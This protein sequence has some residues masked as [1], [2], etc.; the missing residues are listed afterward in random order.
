MKRIKVPAKTVQN[1]SDVFDNLQ[2][3]VA[4]NLLRRQDR[5]YKNY[6]LIFDEKNGSANSLNWKVELV[7]PHTHTKF[8]VKVGESQGTALGL[9][10]SGEII[11][12][13]TDQTVN[14]SSIV[15][16]KYY[17]V[18]VMWSEYGTEPI[19]TADGFLYDASGTTNTQNTSF[20]DRTTISISEYDSLVS[21]FAAADSYVANASDDNKIPLA[22]LKTLPDVNVTWDDTVV[23]DL[24][25]K[26]QLLLNDYLLDD[27]QVLLKDRN[28]TASDGG[29]IDANIDI[30]G[31]LEVDSNVTLNANLSL[32]ESTSPTVTLTE[33]AGSETL[34]ISRGSAN[35]EILSSDN[36]NI[37]STNDSVSIETGTEGKKVVVDDGNVSINVT[38]AQ[39]VPLYVSGDA[40]I[41]EDL[42]VSD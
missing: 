1:F 15:K 3:A 34:A 35:S 31:T 25:Y 37:K 24:R 12:I 18:Y 33:S 19:A 42:T 22:V 41:T 9:I 40:E 16:N 14:P 23:I 4:H 36:L 26:A 30:T 7:Q 28:S 29:A 17:L 38:E 5:L 32:E 6:G 27:S 13:S 39:A 2:D 10:P 21:A 20:L 11:G 8:R